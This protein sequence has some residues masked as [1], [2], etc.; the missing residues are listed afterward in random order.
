MGI[1]LLIINRE[2]QFGTASEDT[3]DS[4]L[5][6]GKTPRGATRTASYQTTPS[7]LV[8]GRRYH[9]ALVRHV[10]SMSAPGDVQSG[11]LRQH[12]TTTMKPAPQRDQMVGSCEAERRWE[13]MQ[14]AEDKAC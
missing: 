9:P 8:L 11:G 2:R 3:P 4:V 6:S 12:R 14:E 7:G 13:K 1:L 5:Q 10:N